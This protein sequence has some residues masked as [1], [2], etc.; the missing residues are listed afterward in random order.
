MLWGPV[1]ELS[2]GSGQVDRSGAGLSGS[3][4][5]LW[6]DWGRFSLEYSAYHSC[7]SKTEKQVRRLRKTKLLSWYAG[8]FL[9]FLT[10]ISSSY[11]FMLRSLFVLDLRPRYTRDK[12]CTQHSRRESKSNKLELN[13]TSRGWTV[14]SVFVWVLTPPL[15]MAVRTPCRELREDWPGQV[16]LYSSRVARASSRLTS[17]SNTIP[18]SSRACTQRLKY[19]LNAHPH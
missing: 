1:C 13:M 9:L 17:T 14:Y 6:S 8:W 15:S 3:S 11:I 19:S 5:R 16:C 12:C 18:F 10:C 7:S 2:C 4:S